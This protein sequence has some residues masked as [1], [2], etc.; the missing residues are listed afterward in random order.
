MSLC[1]FFCAR[2]S[3]KKFNEL[4]LTMR[5]RMIT[6]TLILIVSLTMSAQLKTGYQTDSAKIAEYRE[7]IAIDMSVPDFE[8]KKIDGK[9]MGTHFA[10]LLEFLLENYRQGTYDANIS[11]M[12]KD[13]NETLGKHY[14]SIKKMEFVS[15]AKTGNEINIYMKVGLANNTANV[16]KVYLTIHFKDGI[17]DNHNVNELF[18]NMSRYVQMRENLNQ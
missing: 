5:I 13:Q 14:F 17:G 16:K 1:F 10:N 6:T 8:T 2:K 12:V 11:E 15:A 4:E 9:V 18:S 7:K 3:K